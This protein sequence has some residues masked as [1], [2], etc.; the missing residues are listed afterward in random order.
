MRVNF[1]SNL[2]VSQTTLFYYE[3]SVGHLKVILP[4]RERRQS[5]CQ[6]EY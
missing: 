6:P 5:V 3:K 2:R 4:S 1:D